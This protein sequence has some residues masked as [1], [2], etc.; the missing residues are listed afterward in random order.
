MNGS[1]IISETGAVVLVGGFAP[2]GPLHCEVGP[3]RGGPEVLETFQGSAHLQD[4][5][6]PKAPLRLLQLCVLLSSMTSVNVDVSQSMPLVW[7]RAVCG[8]GFTR[9]ISGLILGW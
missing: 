4:L 8:T 6:L 7:L 1:A 2:N 5:T 3:G 9:P